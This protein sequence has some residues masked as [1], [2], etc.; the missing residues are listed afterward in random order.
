[1]SLYG[2][3]LY[4][5][6][7]LQDVLLETDNPS[8]IAHMLGDLRAFTHFNIFVGLAPLCALMTMARIP[9]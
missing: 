7:E 9:L 5:L 2:Y 4:M 1:M 8:R 6:S 3:F